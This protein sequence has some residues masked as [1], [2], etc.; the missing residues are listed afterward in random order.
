MLTVWYRSSVCEVPYPSSQALTLPLRGAEPAVLASITPALA[1]QPAL[2]DSKPGLTKSCEVVRQV[3]PALA[4]VTDTV[5]LCEPDAAV[6]VIVSVNVC[7]AAADVAE[8]VN[9]A[10]CPEETEPGVMLAV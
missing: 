1:V 6:P 2:P 3:L 8:M 9:V 4:M 7:A 5:V 10:P